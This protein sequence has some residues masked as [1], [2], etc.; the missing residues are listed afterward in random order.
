MKFDIHSLGQLN[1]LIRERREALRGTNPP[2][3]MGKIKDMWLAITQP[4]WE[5]QISKKI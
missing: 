4:S 1:N 3:N 2:I 5:Q